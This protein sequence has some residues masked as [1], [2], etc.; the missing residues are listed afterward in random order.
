MELQILVSKKGTKVVKATNLHLAL[1]LNSDHYAMNVKRWLGD[2]YE[3]ADGGIRKPIKLK[4]YAPTKRKVDE[5]EIVE[6]YYI[7][8]ELAKLITL[9]SKSKLKQ[10]FA[11]WL[12]SLQDK[13]N[14]GD[15]L[16]KDHVISALQLAKAMTTV[17]CQETCERQH[18]KTYE[19]RNGGA[20]NNWW[21]YREHILGYSSSKLKD[22]LKSLGKKTYGKNQRQMLLILDQYEIIRTG[23]ID[24]F[25][26]MGK[27]E[28]YAKNMGDLAK[29]FA[30]ELKLEIVDD[31]DVN[32]KTLFQPIDHSAF[33]KEFTQS[34]VQEQVPVLQ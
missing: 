11:K 28:K 12:S 1:Q 17:S 13:T 34:V 21:K 15:L 5:H 26:G 33:L 18:L 7:S 23:V 2:V 6:D 27:S 32:A 24:L 22:K 25:M 10:K 30:K 9:N 14:N 16:T 19:S 3:F 4:D 8:V 31:R 20:A 29:S